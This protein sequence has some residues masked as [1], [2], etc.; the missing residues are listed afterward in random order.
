VQDFVMRQRL[1]LLLLLLP[2]LSGGCVTRA[3]WTNGYF[4]DVNEPADEANP[5]L[6]DAKP[7]KD[8]LVAYEEYSERSGKT[9]TRAYL[10]NQNEKRVAQ[11]QRPHFVSTNQLHEF[12]PVMVFHAPVGPGTN[13]PPV[14]YAIVQTNHQSFTLYSGE[15]KIGSHDLPVY[16]D[17]VGKYERLA[18]TP[19]A[20]T[21]DLTIIGG[22]LGNSW[23]EGMA[24]NP[25]SYSH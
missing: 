5:R 10:L 2:L 9:H 24:E 4:D 7:Q 20:V 21:A 11:N 17:G 22:I 19:L 23:L 13:M 1:P 16:S 14:L 15:R 6:F 8:L 3:L 25:D 18:W 12:P